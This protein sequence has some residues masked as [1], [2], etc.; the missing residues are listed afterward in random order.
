MRLLTLTLLSLCL[1]QYGYAQTKTLR[2]AIYKGDTIWVQEPIIARSDTTII[3]NKDGKARMYMY[4][5]RMPE[6]PY[7][8]PTYLTNNIRQPD[9]KNSEPTPEKV[10]VRFMVKNDGRIDSAK[11]VKDAP[12]CWE[13]EALRLIRS[14]PPWK[15]GYQNGVPVDVLYT[16]PINCIKVD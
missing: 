2:R 1:F 14:M 8:V 15:P 10:Y 11:V 4:V 16:L 13:K 12:E 3:V 7:D 5:E 9:C 6:A